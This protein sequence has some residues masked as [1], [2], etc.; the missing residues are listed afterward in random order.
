MEEK[1]GDPLLTGL[2]LSLLILLTYAGF[3]AYKSIQWDVL[4]RL[5]AQPLVLPPPATPSATATP[6]AQLSP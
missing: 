4:E 5:E 2:I 1:K 6:S 3:L